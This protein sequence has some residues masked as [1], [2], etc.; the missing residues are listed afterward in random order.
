MELDDTIGGDGDGVPCPGETLLLTIELANNGG[1]DALDLELKLVSGDSA[2]V[3]LDSTAA[4]P[5]IAPG[6]PESNDGDPFVITIAETCE[7]SRSARLWLRL[8]GNTALHQRSILYHLPVGAT[9]QD[10]AGGLALRPCH[11]NP[12]TGST[13]I[14]FHLPE[15]SRADVRIYDVAGRLV[16]NVCDEVMDAGRNQ[17]EWDGT[18]NSGGRVASGVYFVKLMAGND[19]ASRKVVLL[20]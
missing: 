15:R 10:L 13:G 7:E 3:V 16:K 1:G 14:A 12:F 9:P 4:F 8:A 20:K 18:N 17:A 2:V 6:E 11:P 5:D 19:R